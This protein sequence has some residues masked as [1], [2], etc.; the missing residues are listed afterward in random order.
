MNT[1]RKNRRDNG[2]SRKG[3]KSPGSPK[4]KKEVAGMY[5][6][7]TRTHRND[8]TAKKM[9]ASQRRASRMAIMKMKRMGKTMKKAFPSKSPESPINRKENAEMFAEDARTHQNE[10]KQVMASQRRASRMG[11]MKLKRTRRLMKS[12]LPNRSEAVESDDEF[13]DPGNLEEFSDETYN[14]NP[15]V[16]KLLLEHAKRDRS[17]LPPAKRQRL[18]HQSQIHHGYLPPSLKRMCLGCEYTRKKRPSLKNQS[19]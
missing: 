14:F 15:A 4:S 9:I 1:T 17:F 12:M 7:D 3:P 5:A 13:I 8:L 2:S 10:A 11:I 16:R 19:F 18:L 6:E